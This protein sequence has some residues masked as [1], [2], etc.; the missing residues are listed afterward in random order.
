MVSDAIYMRIIESNE[1][2][3]IISFVFIFV[4]I[5]SICSFFAPRSEKTK[6]AREMFADL[7]IVGTI[8]KLAAA[9]G[10]D[11]NNELKELRKF[12]AIE[13]ASRR[14]IDRQIEVELNEKINAQNQKAID[15]INAEDNG[16]YVDYTKK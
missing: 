11:L 13:K 12:E 6:K 4:F 8:R 7:Y 1:T 3:S 5:V 2:M 9:D 14:T 15:K 16:S 10:I